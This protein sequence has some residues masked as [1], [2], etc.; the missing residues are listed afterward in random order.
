[1]VAR[2]GRQ[3]RQHL[4][5]GRMSD[6]HDLNPHPRCKR[7][8]KVEKNDAGR[9]RLQLTRSR[10]LRIHNGMHADPN[11]TGLHE[12]GDPGVGHWL[13]LRET[14]QQGGERDREKEPRRVRLQGVWS[15][16]EANAARAMRGCEAADSG[17]Y[18]SVLRRFDLAKASRA[19]SRNRLWSRSPSL[20]AAIICFARIARTKST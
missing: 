2:A 3:A 9:G 6:R 7:A 17:G 1:H 20:A 10:I 8:S 5:D 16:P 14:C 11:F 4:G 15:A 13:R 19:P 12:I 18:R